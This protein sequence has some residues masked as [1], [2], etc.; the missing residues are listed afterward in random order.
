LIHRLL[1]FRQHHLDVFQQGSYLPLRATGP[2]AD[3][4]ISFARE[5]DGRWIA[6]IAPR[7]SSRVGFPPIG[8]KWQDTILD[9][10]EMLTTKNAA[11]VFTGIHLRVERRQLHL[12]DALSILP[13]AVITNA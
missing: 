2:F 6:V 13:V 8:D 9:L 12:G 1:H 5:V 4:C 7:L 10:P 11:D 3:S